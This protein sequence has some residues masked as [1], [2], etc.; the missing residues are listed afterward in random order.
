[1]DVGRAGCR[2]RPYHG[3][4]SIA[5]VGGDGSRVEGIMELPTDRDGRIEL[6]YADADASLRALGLG[7]LDGFA[8]LEL[9]RG[10]WAGTIDLNRLRR[11]LAQWHYRWVIRGRGHA[12][13]LAL[14]HREH[15]HASQMEA[16]ALEARMARQ[17]NDYRAV[18]TGRMSASS[19]L[20]RH[21]WSPFRHAVEMFAGG[22]ERIEPDPEGD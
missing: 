10:A 13:L 5:A 19:F 12:G 16:L 7:G 18:L 20:E 17:Q 3:T 9:G 11:F 1:L 6:A 14:R 22:H 2:V 21:V 4:V 8:R 15:E